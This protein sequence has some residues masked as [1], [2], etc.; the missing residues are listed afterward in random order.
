MCAT[1]HTSAPRQTEPMLVESAQR[2]RWHATVPPPTA[3]PRLR[4]AASRAWRGMKARPA[5]SSGTRAA[6]S[7][8][9]REPSSGGAPSSYGGY[10]SARSDRDEWAE[11]VDPSL[12]SSLAPQPR[13]LLVAIA[14]TKDQRADH[15]CE[16]LE[17]RK[18][19]HHS[20][21]LLDRGADEGHV[22]DLQRPTDLLEN[23]PSDVPRQGIDTV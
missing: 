11:A 23:V 1:G 18:D 10:A 13:V 19:G 21:E 12:L 3:A 7:E 22:A 15:V 6:L 5:A 17:A 8:P 20:R 16:L 9:P 4:R 2:S 14:R